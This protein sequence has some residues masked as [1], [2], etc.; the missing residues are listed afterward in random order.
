MPE[1]V[2]NI[3]QS[4][5]EWLPRI[6][7][8][9]V[10]MGF[11]RSEIAELKK[12]PTEETAGIAKV[13]GLFDDALIEFAKQEMLLFEEARTSERTHLPWAISELRRPLFAMSTA[14]DEC[15]HSLIAE[16]ESL[17]ITHEGSS[18]LALCH[19][20]G[21]EIFKSHQE[22]CEAILRLIQVIDS[23]LN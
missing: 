4:S 17:R 15:R 6:T 18:T 14:F 23:N 5:L 13:L 3:Y 19:C 11:M 2:N 16:V 12:E 10:N 22:V 9:R 8:I 7:W 20:C 21:A 1:T